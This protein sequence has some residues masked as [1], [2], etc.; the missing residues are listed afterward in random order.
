MVC[1]QGKIG[2]MIIM[3]T[4]K[5]D[6][7]LGECH[8]NTGDVDFC[9]NGIYRVTAPVGCITKAEAEKMLGLVIEG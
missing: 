9:Y 3:K 2:R 6:K 1:W 7:V 5:T 4:P 8:K